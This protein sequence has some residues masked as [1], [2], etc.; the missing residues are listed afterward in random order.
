M[1][2][3]MQRLEEAV[4]DLRAMEALDSL[5]GW[6]QEIH[7]PP[8][9]VEARSGQRARVRRLIHE[10]LTGPELGALLDDAQADQ[11]DARQQAVLR[12]TQRERQRASTLPG[13]LVSAIVQ[14]QGP[15]VEAWK[16]AR[17]ASDFASFQPH[18]E[19]L[20]ALRR[21][22][23][24]ARGHGGERYDALLELHEPGMTVARLAPVLE[25]LKAGLVPMVE[26]IGQRPAPRTDFLFADRWD[27]D[28][29]FAFCRELL[30][31]MGFNLDAGRLDR[32]IHPFCQSTSPTDVRLTTRLFRDDGQTAFFSALHEGGHGLFEQGLP[33]CGTYLAMAPSMGLHESQSRLWE[34]V[35]GRS[36]AF[37]TAWF[38]RLKAKFPH[39]LEGIDLD[40][41]MKAIT[42]VTPSLIRVEADEV[43]Y[44][45]HI[46]MRFELELALLR[47]DLE[48]SDLPDAWNDASERLLG[49]RPP[50]AA[51]GVLQ[52]IHWAWGEFGYFPTY[53]IGN[54]YAASLGK[55]AARALPSLWSQVEAG[56]T[57]A[58]LGWLRDRI[59]R[60][61][62]SLD[63]EDRVRAATGEGLTERDLLAYLR[64]RYLGES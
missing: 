1:G 51:R 31:G 62:W 11:L 12:L 16:H 56:D 10:R 33:T 64:E 19:K 28:D 26:A 44:N 35:V 8:A 29:Q 40:A 58:L 47:G 18:L 59:H 36:R 60:H 54:M 30:G 45:L 27:V 42:R 3:A 39:A 32:S 21:E 38:P 50:D 34:N 49:L 43:T 23:A 4:R 14:A 48:V 22:E 7:L 17:Q 55:A 53:S 46:L 37:W 9:A 5:A 52:D 13:S 15:A 61:G 63:A 6:D 24:D 25:R 2:E 41:W 57:S 20:V